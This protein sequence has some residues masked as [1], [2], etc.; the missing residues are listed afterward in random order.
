MVRKWDAERVGGATRQWLSNWCN[1]EAATRA[2]AAERAAEAIK[3][4]AAAM[5]KAMGA[6]RAKEAKGWT[7]ADRVYKSQWDSAMRQWCEMMDIFA[8]LAEC[9]MQKLG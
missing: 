2:I 7:W 9:R 5:A 8:K 4:K 3:I 1:E 6:L